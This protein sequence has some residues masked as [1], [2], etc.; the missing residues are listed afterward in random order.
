MVGYWVKE[1]NDGE[2]QDGGGKLEPESKRSSGACLYRL[3]QGGEDMAFPLRIHVVF[4]WK[5]DW[6]K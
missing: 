3:T 1:E 5:M 2:I 6:N 4:L